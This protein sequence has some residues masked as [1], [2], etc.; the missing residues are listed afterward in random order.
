MVEISQKDGNPGFRKN[1]SMYRLMLPQPINIEIPNPI[2]EMLLME[3]E[4]KDKLIH[5]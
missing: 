1:H 5:G 2:R 4:K 3:S